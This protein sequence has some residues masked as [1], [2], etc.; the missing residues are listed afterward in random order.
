MQ[1][2][3]F[4]V[5]ALLTTWQFF[6]SAW[7]VPPGIT[8][9]KRLIPELHASLPILSLGN[10]AKIPHDLFQQFVH[11]VAP[12]TTVTTDPKAGGKCAYD[13]DRLVA[14]YDAD[15]GETRVF[16]LIGQLSPAEGHIPTDPAHDYIHNQQIFPKD[17]TIVSATNG[18]SLFGSRSKMGQNSPVPQLYMSNVV[19][20]R[21]ITTNGHSYTVCGPGS[22]ASFGIAADGK[23]HSLSYLWKPATL[24]N[25]TIESHT[26][27]AVFDS[28]V[29]QL[30]PTAAEGI[31]V[32]VEGVDVCFFDSGRKFM[33]P[34]YR[35]TATLHP[36]SHVGGNATAAPTRLLGYVPIGSH[37]PEAIPDLGQRPKH[38]THPTTPN[39]EEDSDSVSDADSRALKPSILVSRY[40]VH[41]DSTQWVNNA[42]N[43]LSSLQSSLFNFVNSQY[44]WAYPFEFTTRKNSF[45]NSVHL[46]ETEVHG[47]WHLFTMFKNFGDVVRLSDIPSDS[48]GGGAGGK[49]AYWIIHS[50]EVIPTPTDYSVTDRHIAFD[51]WFRIFNGMHAVVGY[52]TEMW[53]ADKVMPT[54]GRFIS[55]G[56]PF[57]SSWLQTVHD[58]TSDYLTNG[59]AQLYLD[60]NRHIKEPMGRPSAV[61][62]CG[63]EDDIVAN[64]ENLGRPSCL[65]EFWYENYGKLL[66]EGKS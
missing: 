4:A 18:S 21:N 7:P 14:I 15:S 41:D 2:R 57:I 17:H 44:F 56:A 5:F 65:R 12:H 13:G 28:I 46:A 38:L 37:S 10:H 11:T 9:D 35:F 58:D 1:Q 45:V 27:S 61:V 55:Q 52:C 47:N 25:Q 33:Q 24:T 36:D 62:V 23:V 42:N 66:R 6:T 53:I 43:F 63:H 60:G 39:S 30:A 48:Y 51:D 8:F 49:L 22:S 54:F 16:P 64:L 29:E 40:I 50:C 19:V 34:V 20:R 3:T 59:Q 26:T 32:A 31:P